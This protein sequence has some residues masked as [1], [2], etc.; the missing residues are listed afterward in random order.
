MTDKLCQEKDFTE[1]LGESAR[2][3]SEDALTHGW[4]CVA[5]NI[6]LAGQAISEVT[7]EIS[8]T[9]DD[10]STAAAA[11]REITDLLSASE[12]AERLEIA[13]AELGHAREALEASS[14][15]VDE[16]AGYAGLAASGFLTGAL[17]DL[18]A[19]LLDVA[20]RIATIEDSTRSELD[21]VTRFGEGA[22]A[23]AGPGVPLG[24]DSVRTWIRQLPEEGHGPRR[25]GAQVS[26]RQ[27]TDRALHRIDPITGTTEDGVAAGKNHQC[28]RVAT[29]VNTDAAY[30]CADRYIRATAEFAVARA[31]ALTESQDSW[32]VRIRLSRIFGPTYRQHVSGVRREGS[33]SA[34]TG[35]P[36]K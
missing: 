34:P 21:Q 27:L 16:A 2:L 35:N 14:R 5:G 23:T 10:T 29:R 11:L 28:S 26:L 9:I 7:E 24:V 30:V 19:G 18:P 25:H 20:G 12:V 3:A 13:V 32:M 8:R 17:S 6:E 4:D 22:G 31:G 15:R 1:K 33:V 36:R